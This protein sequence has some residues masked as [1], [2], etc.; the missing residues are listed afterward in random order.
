MREP[1][2]ERLRSDAEKVAEAERRAAAGGKL[3]RA[4]QAGHW[5]GAGQQPGEG[6]Y[7]D[8]HGD[9]D[10]LAFDALY[11][12]NLAAYS[13]LD[14]TG[15]ARGAR[16]RH[17]FAYGPRCVCML[18][19]P[20]RGGMWVFRA[21]QCHG[22]GCALPSKPCTHECCGA[23]TVCCHACSAADGALLL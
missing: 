9:R 15:V 23:R 8:T 11:R 5:T 20:E 2:R 3:T 14:P 10:N 1:Q 21:E 22:Q 17:G 4:P 18:A 13:R 12:L 16:T 7:I 6:Y 19:V